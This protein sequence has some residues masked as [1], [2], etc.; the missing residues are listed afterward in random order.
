VTRHENPGTREHLAEIRNAFFE[1]RY[2]EAQGMCG[3][4]MLGRELNYGTHLP[5]GD[6]LLRFDD[7][8]AEPGDYRRELDLDQALAHVSYALGKTHYNTEVFCSNPDQVLV[9][10][11]DCDTPGGLGFEMGFDSGELPATVRTEDNDT[12]I[13]TGNAYEK[14]HSNGKTGVE[15]VG[16][17]KVIPTGGSVS[18]GDGVLKVADADSVVLLVAINTNYR[19]ADAAALCNSQITAAAEKTYEEVRDVHVADHQRL[20]RRVSLDLGDNGVEDLPTDVLL[21]RL[22]SGAEVPQLIT[23]FYQYGRYLIIAGSREDSPLPLNLQGIW[24][25][26]LACNMGW[27]C[28][29]H[30]DINTQQNYWPAEVCNLSECN[31][32]LF[33]LLE[34]LRTPRQAHCPRSLRL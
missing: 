29:F 30:L 19:N 32:P 10:R 3:K 23:T 11:L 5:M 12:L 7:H 4:Y 14:K 8:G 13:V 25:D 26:N 9:V 27:T 31:T 28:D 18:S 20:F 34:S 16:Q 2:E 6:L 24:N 33:N 21:E 22:K 1:G 15:F 17:I